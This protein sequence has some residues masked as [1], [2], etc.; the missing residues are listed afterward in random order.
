M[1]LS[2][3]AAMIHGKAV[4]ATRLLYRNTYSTSL[5]QVEALYKTQVLI[6]PIESLHERPTS[7]ENR[8]PPFA[9]ATQP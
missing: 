3:Q 5:C 7:H 4:K 1:Y 8:K 2:L 6:V 9:V